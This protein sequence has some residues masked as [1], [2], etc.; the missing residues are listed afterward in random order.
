MYLAKYV[1]E[2]EPY[3]DWMCDS[4]IKEDYWIIY[5]PSVFFALYVKRM[6]F[7][8]RALG[9]LSHFADF[10]EWEARCS[11]ACTIVCSRAIPDDENVALQLKYLQ[12][13]KET[14]PEEYKLMLDKHD[15]DNLSRLQESFFFDF[16][17]DTAF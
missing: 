2:E 4:H 11:K 7:S 12:M 14:F 1:I 3:P 8:I 15:E 6:F 5:V 13:L 17:G 9:L 10:F 16:N